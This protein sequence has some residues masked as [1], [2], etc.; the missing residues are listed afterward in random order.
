MNSMDSH[1]KARFDS[2]SHQRT[3]DAFPLVVGMDVGAI[4]MAI[5]IKLQKAR[6]G[7]VRDEHK[8]SL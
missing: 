8:W 4:D 3:Y 1:R 7:V 5:G 2:M 6:N